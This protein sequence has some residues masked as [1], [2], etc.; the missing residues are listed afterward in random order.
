MQALGQPTKRPSSGCSQIAHSLYSGLRGRNHLRFGDEMNDYEMI[1][2]YNGV[3]MGN[4]VSKV[5]EVAK[6]LT[7]DCKEDGVSYALEELIK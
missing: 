4:A 7:K 6:I 2:T 5:K 3:A 1:K